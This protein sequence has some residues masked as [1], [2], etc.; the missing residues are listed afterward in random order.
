MNKVLKLTAPDGSII[1][2][3]GKPITHSV[4]INGELIE[5]SITFSN[6]N[7]WFFYRL[8]GCS[9]EITLDETHNWEIEEVEND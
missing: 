5:G 6:N 7:I 4:C 2:Y 9:N 1:F 8:Y 3:D